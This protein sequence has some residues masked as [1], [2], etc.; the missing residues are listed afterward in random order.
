MNLSFTGMIDKKNTNF[1]GRSV[2]VWAAF[3]A[4]SATRIVFVE[5]KMNSMLHQ[6]MLVDSWLPVTPLITSGDLTYQQD[7][8][9]HLCK[10]CDVQNKGKQR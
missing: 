9:M 6:D 1:E 3:T 2:I 7:N 8:A 5:N 4:G 10:L